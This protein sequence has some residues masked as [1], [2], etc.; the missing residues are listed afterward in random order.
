MKMRRATKE[1]TN[2]TVTTMNKDFQTIFDRLHDFDCAITGSALRDF[3]AAKDIDVLF[4]STQDFRQ[5]AAEMSVPYRGGFDSGG[6]CVHSLRYNMDGVQKQLN[7]IQ[8]SDVENFEQWPHEVLLRD[9][10]TLNKGQFHTKTP[11]QPPRKTKHS[12]EDDLDDL[13]P[14]HIARCCWCGSA[15]VSEEKKEEF[16][17]EPPAW[18]SGSEK[19]RKRQMDSGI[20]ETVDGVVRW[21]FL[22]T[23]RQVECMTSRVKNLFVWGNRGGGKSVCMRWLCHA[24][25]V[26]IPGFKYSILRTSFVEL[27]KNHLIFLEDE[28]ERMGGTYHKTD[29]ICYYSNGSIGFYSQ[30]ETDD[31]VKKILGAEVALIIFDEAPTFQWDHM[32]LI[33]ASVRVPK[34]YRIR[35][36]VRYLGNPIGESIDELFAY[37]V[38]K[39]VKHD[40]DDEYDPKDWDAIE[41]RLEDNPHLD[42]KDYRKQFSGLKKHIRQ[43]WLHG[44]RAEENSL[45][46]FFPTKFNKSTGDIEPYHVIDEM[47]TLADGT[48]VVYF[49]HEYENDDGS[50]GKWIHPDWVRIYRAYDHGF[51]PDPAVCLWFAIIGRLIV[52]FKEEQWSEVIA[53]DIAKEIVAESKGMWVVTTYNDP[54]IDIKTGHDIYTTKQAM[55]NAGVPMDNGVNDRALFADVI[56][57]ILGE[58]IGPHRPRMVFLKSGCPNLIKFLPRMKWD[59]HDPSKMADHKHDHWPVA[60]AYFAM[61][62]IPTTAP[63]ES[64]RKRKWMQPKKKKNFR[65]M[66]THKRRG[67]FYG[68]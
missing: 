68:R 38:D 44:V 41:M 58:E 61:S 14:E 55:E 6:H 26:A 18:C 7:L 63:G 25:A 60:F 30:C 52:C 47:P 22:P 23:P 45:F 34:T 62:Q 67:R 27:N 5:L 35:P 13:P 31:D 9:G 32:R 21:L 54:S 36:M 50:L 29:H 11:K 49:D 42:Y 65:G 4:K 17:P 24:L 46:E 33:A 12:K 40:E 56:H 37:C 48:P 59:K 39:D 43:A 19:C 51:K 10:S 8:R 15:L 20:T 2:P 57:R 1:T 3:E 16:G 66:M 53:P 64:V 28:M